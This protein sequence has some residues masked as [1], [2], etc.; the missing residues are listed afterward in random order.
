MGKKLDLTGQKFTSL[1]VEYEADSVPGSRIKW[2]CVCD[3]GKHRVVAGDKLK[4]GRVISCGCH[5]LTSDGDSINHSRY[6]LY[7]TA[8]GKGSN[9]GAITQRIQRTIIMGNVELLSVKSGII[10]I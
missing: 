5:K 1:T 6:N 3:C 7:C 10:H 9:K 2:L 8:Y 4:S